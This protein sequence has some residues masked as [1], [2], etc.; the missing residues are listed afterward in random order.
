MK[1]EKEDEEDKKKH[2]NDG[3][4]DGDG[5]GND[6]DDDDEDDDDDDGDYFDHGCFNNTFINIEAVSVS[7]RQVSI[8]PGIDIEPNRNPRVSKP[9]ASPIEHGSKSAI[10]GPHRGLRS[11]GRHRPQGGARA[12]NKLKH[13]KGSN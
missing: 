8:I 11:Q 5:D 12:S 4:G 1:Q 9:T 13:V 6:V 2:N 7:N 10:Q 3:D